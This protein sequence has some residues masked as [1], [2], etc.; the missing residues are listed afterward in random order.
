MGADSLQRAIA[1]ASHLGVGLADKQQALLS[2]YHRW[3][4]EEAIPG[5]GVGPHE[6]N[7]LWDRHI[8]DSI[9]FGIGVS[10]SSSCLDIG[11]GVGLPGIPLAVAYPQT[12]FVLLDRSGRRC[13]LVRRAIAVLGLANCVVTHSEIKQFSGRFESIVSRAAIPPD[14]ILFHVKRLLAPGGVAI[15]GLSRAGRGDFDTIKD[16][17]LTVSVVASPPEILDSTAH[18]LRIEST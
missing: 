1:V 10:E 14:Q 8:A 6:K 9:L 5:G 2:R 13:D 15:L 11:T 3:L 17:E 12:D 7:R 4:I 16:D 18:L